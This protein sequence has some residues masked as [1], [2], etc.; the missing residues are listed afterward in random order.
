MWVEAGTPSRG[1]GVD[2][3][4]C[5]ELMAL[6]AM[7]D[8]ARAVDDFVALGAT[9]LPGGKLC[10]LSDNYVKIVLRLPAG[11][12]FKAEENGI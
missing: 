8:R 5:E 9:T 7:T 6:G 2:D 11:G 12:K 10:N 1:R 3:W 4:A